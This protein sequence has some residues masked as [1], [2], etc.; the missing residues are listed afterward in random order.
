NA[1]FGPGSQENNHFDF[2]YEAREKAVMDQ[3][4]YAVGQV[5]GV[6]R[7]MHMGV[8]QKEKRNR[9]PRSEKKPVSRE[10]KKEVPRRHHPRKK[11]TRH[12]EA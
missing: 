6:F 3:V 8:R 11:M 4:A 5:P 1:H 9:A 10:E 12:G 2:Q 7:V